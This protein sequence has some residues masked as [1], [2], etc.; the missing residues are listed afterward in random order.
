MSDIY[1]YESFMASG[2]LSKEALTEPNVW[3]NQDRPNQ[4]AVPQ[5]AAPGPWWQA[6][7]PGLLVLAWVVGFEVVVIGGALWIE[8]LTGK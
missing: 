5:Q 6:P 4:P 3:P 2:G 7:L 1:T 8:S